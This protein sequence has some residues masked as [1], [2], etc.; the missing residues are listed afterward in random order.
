ML[1][2]NHT[3]NLTIF[4]Y[5]HYHCRD[6]NHNH[7]HKTCFSIESKTD[8][9]QSIWLQKLASEVILLLSL[10]ESTLKLHDLAGRNQ[11]I[12]QLQGKLLDYTAPPASL[13][14]RSVT[15]RFCYP[16]HV[17]SLLGYKPKHLIR[18]Y[19][20]HRQRLVTEK[21]HGRSL[22]TYNV[23]RTAISA[24]RI[25]LDYLLYLTVFMV[26]YEMIVS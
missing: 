1:V 24:V 10:A 6:H 15:T 2:S 8:K 19:S 11:P 3:T 16:F 14:A 17:V 5:H 18:Y 22:L 25:R 20:K 9:Y 12:Q 4:N 21:E 13:Q 23:Q 26:R 7:N